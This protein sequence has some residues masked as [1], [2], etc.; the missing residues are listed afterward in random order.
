MVGT[1]QYM[2]PEQARGLDI[3]KR[4]DIYALG[5]IIYE[6]LVGQPPFVSDSPMEI[7]A[8]HL[9][10]PVVPPSTYVS[11]ISPELDEIVVAML[12]KDPDG[13]PA[14]VEVY[15]VAERIRQQ[16]PSHQITH[17]RL[18][19]AAAEI[20]SSASNPVVVR[21]SDKVRAA[22]QRVVTQV[23]RQSSWLPPLRFIA[24]TL[25]LMIASA[26]GM[27]FLMRAL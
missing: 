16:H 19:G 6:M 13:R 12:S 8:K 24:I 23:S 27:Y 18:D 2:A 4:V 22:E 10:E 20:T 11:A 26:I 1:P 15:E 7:V 9:T 17:V 3:D 25:V 14:L 5:G 21:F